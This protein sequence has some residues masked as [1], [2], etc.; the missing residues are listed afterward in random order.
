[1]KSENQAALHAAPSLRDQTV[2]LG[3]VDCGRAV[4]DGAGRDKV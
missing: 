4:R 1:M 3:E 2:N